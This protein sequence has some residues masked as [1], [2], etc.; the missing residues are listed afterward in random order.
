MRSAFKQALRIHLE[1]Y[2]TIVTI[3]E[4][5]VLWN[6]LPETTR[7]VLALQEHLYCP[8]LQR[9]FTSENERKQC[10]LKEY[11]F[12]FTDSMSSTNTNSTITT[13]LNN[14]NNTEENTI[15]IWKTVNK[16]INEL[17]PTLLPNSNFQLLRET[18]A[19]QLQ[20]SLLTENAIPI[21][22]EVALFGSSANSFGSD[23]ADL[24]MTLLFPASV[25][26]TAEDKPIVIE[27]LGAVLSKFGMSDVSV[28]ATARIPIV[29][30]KDPLHGKQHSTI[31]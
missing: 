10:R 22:T 19:G 29:Q 16:C 20:L 15:L 1:A 11:G 27:R 7:S 8:H 17:I 2:E 14:N 31:V 9:C 25:Q 21:G 12:D 18:A 5:R 26:I 4:S 24:D 23:G 13:R 6:M 30:F 28:R 3:M